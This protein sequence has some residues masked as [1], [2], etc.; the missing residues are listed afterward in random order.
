MPG[1]LKLLS[2]NIQKFGEDKMDDTSF[3]EYVSR[4]IQ[5]TEAD[6]VGIME[7]VGWL[8]NEIRD[9][10][11][12]CL[13][14]LEKKKN[15][16]KGS[17]ITWTGEASEMT[18][19]RP[20]EQYVFLWKS[21]LFSRQ[22]S[23]LWNVVGENMFDTYFKSYKVSKSNQELFWKS[24]FKNGWLDA[25]FMIPYKKFE[26]MLKDY[27]L[28]DLTK[29]APTIALT[30]AQKKDIVDLLLADTP[31]AFPLRGSRPP[32]VL[33]ALTSGTNVDLT[34]VLYHAP[35]PGDSLP[36]IASNQ[37]N[38]TIENAAVGVIMGDFNVNATDAAKQ[39]ALN[40]FDMSLGRL[41]YV[42]DAQ[43][44]YIN[45]HPFQRITGPDFPKPASNPAL[46]T[47]LNYGK[48]LWSSKTSL[49]SMLVNPSTTVASP[50][51]IESVLSSEYDKFFVKAPKADPS[52]AFVVN[53]MDVMIP[54]SVQTG[55][56][57]DGTPIMVTRSTTTASYSLELGTLAQTIYNNWWD[58]QNAKKRKSKALTDMLNAA[59][60]L[61]GPPSSMFEAHYVYHHAISDH[62]P[63]RMELQY[64]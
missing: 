34:L 56:Q 4:V 7:L 11:V 48:R 16:G 8:G 26:L 42:R 57:L 55:V 29:K 58:R 27:K 51:N 43:N 44:A 52:A 3:I 24:L 40:Y 14:N 41:Q 18:P 47:V 19:A 39:W 59:P 50:T 28:L 25:A 37:L 21:G 60:K 54:K 22:A 35:G 49:T 20:N 45:A 6:V 32:F 61:T 12:T 53:L 23:L 17:G 64:V 10:L 36:I 5:L 9:T 2:W 1:S 13:N 33:R 62:L 38:P 46:S 31:E 63:I 30:D 15:N